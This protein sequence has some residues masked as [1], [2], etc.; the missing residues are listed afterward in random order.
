MNC[1]ETAQDKLGQP[2]YE[3][4]NMK[5]FNRLSFDF[6]GLRRF[7]YEG[8]KFGYFLKT[9][10]YFIT[11]NPGGSTDAVVRHVSIVQIILLCYVTTGDSV[12]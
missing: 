8:F 2:A 6:L 3:I 9:H 10:Y 12:S 5:N 4:L 7:P 1:A 11:H